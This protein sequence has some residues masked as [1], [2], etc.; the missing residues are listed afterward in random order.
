MRPFLTFLITFCTLLFFSLG[1]AGVDGPDE[2]IARL[3][4]F[5]YRAYYGLAQPVNLKQAL[6]F[7]RQAA[8]KGDAEAQYIYGGM[9]FQG[10]GVDPDKRSGFKWLMQAAEGGKT[11]PESLA[12]IGSM[13]LRGFTVP[14][15]FLEAKKWLSRGAEQGDMSA[16]VDLAY[17]HYHGL[18]GDRDYTK[19]LALYEKAALQGDPIAQANTGMMYANGTGTNTDRSKGYA[20][21]SLAASRGNTTA[22]INRNDLMVDMSWEE[23]NQAQAF[24]LDLYRRVENIKQ[25]KLI[26]PQ[27]QTINK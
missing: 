25:P 6:D 9:L 27:S 26:A 11:T 21:Y 12:I 16:Q 4:S 1:H 10:Q 13:Y 18:G 23:L 3:K 17:M 7:Y 19:A 24:S 2:I 22:A 8:E 5:G 14:Q 20:W 15:N